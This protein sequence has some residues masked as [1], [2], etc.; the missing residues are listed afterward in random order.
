MYVNLCMIVTGNVYAYV[1]VSVS[2]L[3]YESAVYD[4]GLQVLSA[5][6]TEQRSI[7]GDGWLFNI[8]IWIQANTSKGNSLLK[9]ITPLS[10]YHILLK[11]STQLYISASQWHSNDIVPRPTNY[12]PSSPKTKL[13]ITN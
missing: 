2:Q 6:A 9:V 10:H 5:D 11:I 12:H 4:V 7:P 1:L 13:E 3:Q 8:P